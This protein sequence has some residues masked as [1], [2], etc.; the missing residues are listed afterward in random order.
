MALLAVLDGGERARDLCAFLGDEERERSEAAIIRFLQVRKDSGEALKMR[1][2]ALASSDTFSGIAEIHPAW[3]LDAIR[4]EPPRIMGVIM[5][6]LPSKHVRYILERLPA[7][8]K[9]RIPKLIESFA[10]PQDVL[11]IIRQQFEARFLPMRISKALAHFELEHLYYLKGD[12]L[13]VLYRELGMCELALALIGMSGKIVRVVLNRLNL[14]DAK[15][16]HMRIDE[17]AKSSRELRQQAR[18]ALLEIDDDASSSDELLIDIGLA[19][20]SRAL[21]NV[22]ESVIERMCQKLE[23]R[24]AS[25]LRRCIADSASSTPPAL[26]D[27]RTVL[28]LS[29]IAS[30]A[31][32]DRVDSQWVRFA[33]SNPGEAAA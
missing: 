19:S 27:E 7:D 2:K 15:R 22:E 28:V 17:L 32:E 3:I 16:L 6:Y 14:K 26:I 1:L 21:V 29:S 4:Y 10:V 24:V 31:R 20:F 12:E 5:R 9:D 30:L 11:S 8:V 23:P 33:P 18:Y 13:E 25:V